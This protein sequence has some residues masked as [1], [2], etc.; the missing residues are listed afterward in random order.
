MSEKTEYQTSL[1]DLLNVISSMVIDLSEE[2]NEHNDELR[3]YLASVLIF[4][5]EQNRKRK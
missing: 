5:I 1:D 2:E 3:E 4:L